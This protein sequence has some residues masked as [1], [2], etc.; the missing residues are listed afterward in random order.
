MEPSTM[1]PPL[2]ERLSR[3]PPPCNDENIGAA[4]VN[5]TPSFASASGPAAGSQ[6]KQTP[7]ITLRSPQ[8]STDVLSSPPST[9]LTSQHLLPE[10]ISSA[11]PSSGARPSMQIAVREANLDETTHS[12]HRR[13]LGE[14]S[15]PPPEPMSWRPASPRVAAASRG[16]GTEAAII[17]ADNS[18][19]LRPASDVSAVTGLCDLPNE[20]LLQILRYLDV[21]DLL[22]TSRTSHRLRSLSLAPILHA[23]RL[24]R[25]RALLPPLLWSP[26]RPSLA[27]LARRRIFQTRTTVVSRQL[28][29]SLVSIRL[30]RRLAARPP[31]ESLVERAVLPPEC[32]P[33]STTTRRKASLA[34]AL[35]AKKRAVERERVK[36]G[37]RR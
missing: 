18:W 34:P 9:G 12:S 35:V 13:H 16:G 14:A 28:A 11:D 25:A 15:E 36:D 26:F 1:A 37:L 31:I 32:L 7:H 6:D 27:D 4:D 22:C 2:P 19:P 21:C 23:H 8:S 3:Q 20:V 30:S 17:E 24:R 33:P 10:V 5:A 29:R